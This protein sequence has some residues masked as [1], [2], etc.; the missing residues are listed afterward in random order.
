MRESTSEGEVIEERRKTQIQNVGQSFINS[1]VS[2]TDKSKDRSP[3]M[4][5]VMININPNNHRVLLF[6]SKV[7]RQ[8]C[9]T[10]A[11]YQRRLNSPELSAQF[12]VYLKRNL[13]C[14]T[15]KLLLL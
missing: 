2:A 4:S 12:D 10:V 15:T 1:L 6:K 7:T 9:D 13:L 3:A 5:A 14:D 8:S 11:S